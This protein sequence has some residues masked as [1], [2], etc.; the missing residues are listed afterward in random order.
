M[1][2]VLTENI[3]VKGSSE[4]QSSN[5]PVLTSP[6]FLHITF[7]SSTVFSTFSANSVHSMAT[8]PTLGLGTLQAKDPEQLEAAV[9]YAL[10]VVG[11]R[12]IDTAWSYEN[13]AFI[14]SALSKVF[15]KGAIK[16]EELFL[17]TK[18]SNY[19][20]Q[21]EAVE[22]ACRLQLERL[23]V[24]YLDLFLMH[25][26]LAFAPI[27]GVESHGVKVPDVKILPI[28]I[29]DTWAAMERLVD[30]GLVR[31]IGVS[32]FSIEMLERLR[33]NSRIQPITNQVELNLYQQQAALINYMEWRGN[34]VLTAYSPLGQNKI[35]P[36]GV[37]MLEDPVLK[38]I[39]QEIGKTTAQVALKFLTKLSPIVKI[40]PKSVNPVRISEN[41]ALDFD[42]T[43]EQVEKLKGRD[44]N[45]RFFDPFKTWGVDVFS[46]GV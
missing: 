26:P 9:I 42:L 15:A 16:R 19:R 43:V 6:H 46:L 31:Y 8:F 38:E 30:L 5:S 1:K 4:G 12:H 22:P 2:V 10:E 44:R 33:F 17:T 34:L 24:A 37:P 3:A 23:G 18:L 14:G 13:E 20:H 41:N 11:I 35:G 27:P 36:F 28:D 39:A 29:L 45:N 25:W 40:I 32:N 21:P 7:N